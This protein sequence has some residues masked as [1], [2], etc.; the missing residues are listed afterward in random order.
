MSLRY[1]I[2]PINAKRLL[3]SIGSLIDLNATV[4]YFSNDFPIYERCLNTAKIWHGM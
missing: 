1:Q 3:I 2:S 4:L